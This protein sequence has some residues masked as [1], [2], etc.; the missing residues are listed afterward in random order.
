[1]IEFDWRIDVKRASETVAAMSVPT[2]LVQL[3]VSIIIII[4]IIIIIHFLT[5]VINQK[6]K[7][8]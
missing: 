4:I 8:I 2:V 3:Q 1:L 5:N 6:K 7:N